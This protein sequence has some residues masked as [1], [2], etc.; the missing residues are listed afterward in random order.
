MLLEHLAM[1]FLTVAPRLFSATRR[2]RAAQDLQPATP[3]KPPPQAA[4]GPRFKP[5]TAPGDTLRSGAS[6][7]SL[8]RAR[9]GWWHKPKRPPGTV[10][11]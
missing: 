7:D 11:D 2:L 8:R 9:R 3:P 6:A 1:T 5:N 4:P 10:S